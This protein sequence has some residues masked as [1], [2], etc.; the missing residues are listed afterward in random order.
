[1]PGKTPLK[2]FN[3]EMPRI[4]GLPDAASAPST[5]PVTPTPERSSS[6]A[7]GKTAL[8]SI[9]LGITLVLVGGV[10]WWAL[11]SASRRPQAAADLQETT[12]PPIDIAP[13]SEPKSSGPVVAASLSELARPWSAKEF[14][15]VD[16]LTHE[17]V[18][19]MVVHL[20]GGAPGSSSS[21]WA[22]SL[23][24]PYQTSCHLVYVADLSELA[25]RY[26]YQGTHPMVAS[27]CDGTIYDPLKLGTIASGAW[28]RGDVVQGAGIRPPISIEVKIEGN[29]LIADRIE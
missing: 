19:A 11:H 23:D 21:Y 16:P 4:P 18:P 27:P 20:A 2:Q 15:F 5:Q 25:A 26:S 13:S 28:I 29:E 8:L 6:T 22:F 12:A 7:P 1:M 17:S 3:T 14:T 24:A 9:A 10:G